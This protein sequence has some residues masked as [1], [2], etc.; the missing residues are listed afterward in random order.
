MR[1]YVALTT[2]LVMLPLLLLTGI[3]SLYGNISTLIVG[4]MNYD[5]EILRSNS[6]T[7][8]E[9]AVYRIRRGETYVGEFDV[10]MDNWICNVTVTNKDGF[11]GIKIIHILATDD[12]GISLKNDTELNTNTDPFEI[13]NI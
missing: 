12:N 9:E 8:L 6:E 5:Y 11:P 13:S 1:G 3:T 2:V 10:S 4:K 7:C